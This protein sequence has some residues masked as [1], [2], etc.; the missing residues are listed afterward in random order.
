MFWPCCALIFLV[1]YYGPLQ[2]SESNLVPFFT[3]HPVFI[4]CQGCWTVECCKKI[5]PLKIA[6]RAVRGSSLLADTICYTTQHWLQLLYLLMYNVDG[7]PCRTVYPFGSL[8]QRIS[9]PASIWACT[10]VKVPK[11]Q[12]KQN[13]QTNEGQMIFHMNMFQLHFRD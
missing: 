10:T 1:G 2:P 9:A 7:I 12:I 13:K 6:A 8:N 11:P 3:E 4:L 5:T